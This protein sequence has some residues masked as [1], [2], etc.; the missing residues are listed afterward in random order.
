MLASVLPDVLIN[1][2]SDD[3]FKCLIGDVWPQIG[4]IWPFDRAK[5]FAMATGNFFSAMY[6]NSKIFTF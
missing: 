4:D 5:N 2:Q 6:E 1:H 3:V